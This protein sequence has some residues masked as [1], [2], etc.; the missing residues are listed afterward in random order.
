LAYP[1]TLCESVDDAG[2]IVKNMNF[3]AYDT[4]TMFLYI[5]DA[6]ID[7]AGGMIFIKTSPNW[8][9]HQ[10]DWVN[11]SLGTWNKLTMSLSGMND[12]DY[13][14]ELGFLICGLGSGEATLYID[15][16]G[17][18]KLLM[19]DTTPSGPPTG[20]A[21]APVKTGTL[22]I[23]W[24]NPTDLDL[25]HIRIYRSTVPGE[26]GDLAYDN[27]IGTYKQD[28]GLALGTTYCY[29]LR[30]VDL[31]GNESTNTDQHSG[32]PAALVNL[33]L[34]KSAEASSKEEY[35]EWYTGEPSDA[36]DGDMGTRWASECSDPQWIWVDF[37]ASYQLNR[38]V[39]YWEHV[40]GRAYEI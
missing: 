37:G 26:L 2:S 40:Y 29:T 22:N 13:V 5:P 19:P 34:G 23:S 30:S 20:I 3:G 16:V 11:F 12:L 7:W 25:S 17:I 15:Y 24:T 33:A 4:V 39:L 14:R 8:V 38:V 21:V 1:L 28:T 18:G 36:C 6:D 31:S 35:T 27:V 32:V 9:W 10:G